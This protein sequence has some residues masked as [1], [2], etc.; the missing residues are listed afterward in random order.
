VAL[1]FHFVW[2]QQIKQ[3]LHEKKGTYVQL[4]GKNTVGNNHKVQR[5]RFIKSYYFQKKIFIQISAIVPV[6]I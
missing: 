4:K 1:R 6:W 2:K 5:F 3:L